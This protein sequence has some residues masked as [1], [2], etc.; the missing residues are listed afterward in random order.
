MAI[1]ILMMGPMGPI[2]RGLVYDFT[3][4]RLPPEGEREAFLARSGANIRGVVAYSGAALLDE[5]LLARLPNVEIVTNMGV[6]Y[7]T[8]DLD[9]AK[10]RGLIVTN[11]GS[12]NAED[13]AE[14]A[15]GLML[16]VARNISAGDRHVRSG[17]WPIKGRMPMTHRVTGRKLGI[18]GLGH[19]GLGVARRAEAFAMPVAYHNRRP[20]PDVPYRYV[21]NLVELAREVDFLVAATPGGDETRNLINREVLDA[22]GPEGFV[23]NVGRGSVI[24]EAALI[25]A[26][27]EKRLAGAGLDVFADEPNVPA[28]LIALPNVVLQPHQAGATYEG[29][30]AAVDLVISNMKAHFA[31]GA[32]QNRVA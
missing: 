14:H 20:R 21:A 13:V 7:E 6:G 26:L 8:V 19:I 17:Q 11:A 9:A 24:D 15:F 5:R 12:V 25:D 4:H 29:V 10:A 22:L 1:E 3:L 18:L 28:A 31:G 32:V 2:E 27:Q 23:V 30:A 16:D